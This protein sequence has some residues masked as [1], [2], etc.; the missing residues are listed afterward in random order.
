[1]LDV[2]M[3]FSRPLGFLTTE[4]LLD[5]CLH[6]LGSELHLLA[7]MQDCVCMQILLSKHS[8][9]TESCNL[10]VASLHTPCCLKFLQLIVSNLEVIALSWLIQFLMTMLMEVLVCFK[11]PTAGIISLLTQFCTSVLLNIVVHP[12]LTY[13]HQSPYHQGLHSQLC[14]PSCSNSCKPQPVSNFQPSTV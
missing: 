10:C 3:A 2:Q 11:E 6:K 9:C 8:E 14:N 12:K 7:W 1:M 5:H 13:E 4:G